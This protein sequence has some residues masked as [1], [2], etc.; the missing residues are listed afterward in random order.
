MPNSEERDTVKACDPDRTRTHRQPCEVQPMQHAR[1]LNSQ[2]ENHDRR[3]GC[4]DIPFVFVT[5]HS[6]VQFQEAP[7]L[8]FKAEGA[9]GGFERRAITHVHGIC[10]TWY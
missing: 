3:I 5:F 9:I 8:P 10:F 1:H 4:V 2:H 6:V 7:S